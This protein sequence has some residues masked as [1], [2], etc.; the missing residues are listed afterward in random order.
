MLGLKM[1]G[2]PMSFLNKIKLR[3]ARPLKSFAAM[4]FSL[5]DFTFEKNGNR[6]FVSFPDFGNS[7]SEERNTPDYSGELILS[8]GRIDGKEKMYLSHIDWD[9]TPHNADEIEQFIDE[10]LDAIILKA[11]QDNYR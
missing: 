9:K 4:N 3:E 8:S 6:Y 10:H 11:K 7:P 2:N 5:D 1:R